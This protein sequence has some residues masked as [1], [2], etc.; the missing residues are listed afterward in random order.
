MIGSCTKLVWKWISQ[1]SEDYVEERPKAKRMGSKL[2][3]D[4]GLGYLLLPL[5]DAS[6]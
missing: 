2:C 3:L 6:E 1:V 4:N 5:V